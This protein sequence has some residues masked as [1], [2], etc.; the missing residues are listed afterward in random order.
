MQANAEV[1]I[2][3][4]TQLA[5]VVSFASQ[6]WHVLKLHAG[7][8]VAGACD[9]GRRFR[10]T[11]GDLDLLPAKTSATWRVEAASTS[12]TVGLAPSL[13]ERAATEMQ[14]ELTD[15]A[16][17]YQFRDEQLEHIA[18]TL[19]AER[20][21]G[22]ANGSLFSECLGMSLAVRLL[23]SRA[24]L[25]ASSPGLPLQRLRRVIDHIESHLT[26]ALS[27]RELAAVAGLSASHFRAQ[28]KRSM[29]LPV[30]EYVIRRR[31]DH[32]RQLLLQRKVP[33]SQV[34]LAVGFAHQ[35]HMARHM[36]RVLGVT[37]SR[38]LR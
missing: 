21:G 6:P 29:G 10:Y 1:Q 13:L 23:R 35:S 19:D 26:E 20:V 2:G 33:V 14:V 4:Q 31:V 11:R 34:A 17:R 37:P 8:P 7:R 24:S 36:R 5:G 15:I 12:V 18:W 25:P 22:F 3:L 16:A 27:L 38:L 30:Y 9:L 28:F 32:A